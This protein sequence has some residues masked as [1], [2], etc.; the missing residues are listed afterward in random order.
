MGRGGATPN[1]VLNLKRTA[2]FAQ[3]L[4]NAAQFLGVA[5]RLVQ[6]EALLHLQFDGQEPLGIVGGG[7]GA[8]VRRGGGDVAQAGEVGL[9]GILAAAQNFG[10]RVSA[11]L[12]MGAVSDIRISAD[13]GEVF[14]YSSGKS[15]LALITPKDGN[16]GLLHLEAGAMVRDT[17]VRFLKALLP[18][19]ET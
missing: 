13:N 1:V 10:S 16:A 9:R 14:V 11:G 5:P 18:V 15:V 7:V 4:N 6:G 8:A 2:D 19:L 12:N 17:L 3:I